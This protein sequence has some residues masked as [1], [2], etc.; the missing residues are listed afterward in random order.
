MTAF[1]AILLL[2]GVM[3]LVGALVQR[4]RAGRLAETPFASTGQ[5]GAQGRTLA[6]PKGAISTQGQ[7]QTSSLLTSPVS[8][9]PCVYFAMKLEVEWGD[10]SAKSKF[11]VTEDR[12]SV[13]FAVNDG[14]G[15]AVVSIDPTRGGEFCAT[16]PFER[17]KFSRGLLASV[18]QKPIEVTP[19]F[20]IPAALQVAGP[21]GRM[22]EV[23]VTAT[24]FLTEE[25]LE[26]KG[27]LYV[28]GK[29]ADDGSITS[30]TW[31][32]LLIQNRSRD[33]LLAASTGLS[34]KV[35]IAGVIAA[36]IGAVLSIV[37]YLTRPPEPPPAAAP[38]PTAQAAPA[39]AAPAAPE[40]PGNA[41]VTS[42]LVTSGGCSA[43][44]LAPSAVR[45]MPAD[46]AINVVAIVGGTLN[47]IYVKLGA[48]TAG[49]TVDVCAIG[50]RCAQNLQ[51]GVGPTTFINTGRGV[52]GT[53]TVT[54]FAP[55][56]GRMN[57]TFHGVR[58]P[59]NQGEGECVVDGSITTAGL[60]P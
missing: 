6:S 2:V 10:D 7:V 59:R 17:K 44:D 48:V 32:S 42:S 57:V 60:S 15:P 28:N 45:V 9:A 35:F 56:A 3:A 36:P 5:V 58:L 1:G 12:Q 47:R 40:V 13:P 41:L 24:F 55:A 34:K 49:Q 25:F 22:I 21:L 14:S 39:P 18:G 52:G 43:L 11:T 16:K 54:E 38:A 46:D 8:G 50:R 26:P 29:L 37:G 33:E 4:M 31:T 30:P 23:P 19:R 20:S 27:P 53:V 51:V